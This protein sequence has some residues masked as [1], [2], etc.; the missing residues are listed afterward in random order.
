[1]LLL[2]FSRCDYSYCCYYF[3]A[4]VPVVVTRVLLCASAHSLSIV[5]PYVDVDLIVLRTR[6]YSFDHSTLSPNHINQT[7]PGPG[8]GLGVGVLWLWA[9]PG[10][11]PGSDPGRGLGLGLDLGVAWAWPGP[12]LGV[13][14][15]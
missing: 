4:D 2:L 1:M 6:S 5:E 8:R 12:G 15:A 3:V 9:W 13:V 7:G 10:P 11:G 14:W